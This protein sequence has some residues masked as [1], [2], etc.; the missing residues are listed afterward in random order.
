MVRIFNNVF[1]KGA[2]SMKHVFVNRDKIGRCPFCN[3]IV[4]ADHLFVEEDSEVFHY[5]C[6]NEKVK[7]EDNN[8]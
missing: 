2:L 8:E 5:S 6:H 3:D 7:E 1:G 4:Y